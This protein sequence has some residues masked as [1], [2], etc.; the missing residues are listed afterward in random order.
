M[1]MPFSIIHKKIAFRT[2]TILPWYTSSSNKKIK[3]AIMVKIISN[4]HCCV[5]TMTIIWEGRIIQTEIAFAVVEKKTELHLTAI[6]WF[7]VASGTNKEIQVSVVIR[8]E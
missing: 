2:S 6:W 5:G 1:E 4:G 3:A 8:I 7:I